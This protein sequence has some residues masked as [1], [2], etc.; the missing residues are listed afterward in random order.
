MKILSLVAER[1]ASRRTRQSSRSGGFLWSS[2]GCA[3][4][5]LASCAE[6]PR[7]R[8][9]E[10][11]RTWTPAG[12]EPSY[13]ASTAERFRFTVRAAAGLD[14]S[15]PI[16]WETPEGWREL[17]PTSLR[18]ANF[19]VGDGGEVECYLT[20]LAGDGGGEAGNV[21]R[22]LRQMSLEPLD[23][24]EV[25]ELPRAALLGLEGAFLDVTGKFG[26]MEG[27]PSDVPYRLLGIAAVGD[28][29]SAFL[30]LVGPVELVEP[31]VE[32][33]FAVARSFHDGSSH[34]HDEPQ[35][36]HAADA[37]DSSRGATGM[38]FEAP[39]G[40]TRGPARTMREVTFE[41]GDPPAEC[42]VAILGGTG[43]GVLSNVN[44]WR[45]QMGAPVLESTDDLERTS[46]LGTEA[47]LVEVAG[48][49]TGQAGEQV[50]DALLLGAV[51]LLPDRSVFVKMVGPVGSVAPECEAFRRFC[52]SL[53]FP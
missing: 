37:G 26:G 3:A 24:R 12:E 22:W 16:H 25:A 4:L 32:R 2:L 53:S 35:G 50:E 6:A 42:Y 36:A 15:T 41:V 44:R 20:L 51:A 17:E 5:A 39:E 8:A 48:S 46:M 29:G 14:P 34:S 23:D 21:N 47:F 45:S 43:G 7:V 38:S 33:F 11:S 31:E 30:K 10:K 49:F 19:V 27:T 18:Q 52:S 28:A 40:W 13:D 9:I 1:P